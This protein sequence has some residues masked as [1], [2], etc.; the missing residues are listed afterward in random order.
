M[1]SYEFLH[2][3]RALQRYIIC[4]AFLKQILHHISLYGN[5]VTYDVIVWCLIT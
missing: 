3:C 1:L 2:I 4:W 5:H